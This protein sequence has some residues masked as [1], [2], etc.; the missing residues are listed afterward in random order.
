M[1]R[2]LAGRGGAHEAVGRGL[3]GQPLAAGRAADDPARLP[4]L[5]G[6]ARLPEPRRS[7]RI[8]CPFHSDAQWRRLRNGDPDAW[9]DAVAVD[10]AIRT[11]F[12]VIRG[13]VYIHRSA[14]PFDEAD[15]MTEADRGQLDLW[16]NECEGLC[17]V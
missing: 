9:A 2:H 16:P 14:V 3:V 5:A 12:R 1:D 13:E 17:G 8:G 7:A 11:G 6:P 15:L 4:A 10:R